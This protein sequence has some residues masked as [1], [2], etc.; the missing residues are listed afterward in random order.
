MPPWDT[1]RQCYFSTWCWRGT[2][3]PHLVYSG[4]E[5]SPFWARGPAEGGAAA[6]IYRAEGLGRP[7]PQ[8]SGAGAPGRS[9]LLAVGASLGCAALGSS[10]WTH[11]AHLAVS[12]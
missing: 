11:F 12:G 1:E 2:T 9:G 4:V 8:R 3:V 6:A 10:P 5:A 7:S